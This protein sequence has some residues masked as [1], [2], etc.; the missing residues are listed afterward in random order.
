MN[1]QGTAVVVPRASEVAVQACLR[2]HYQSWSRDS[3]V[4]DR[5]E[6]EA[7]RPIAWIIWRRLELALRMSMLIDPNLDSPRR[8]YAQ[9]YSFVRVSHTV[10]FEN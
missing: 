7:V 8:V 2:R 4:A 10:N 3:T 1:R 6:R 9:L 5:T